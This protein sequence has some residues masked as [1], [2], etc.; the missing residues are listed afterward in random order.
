M[1]KSK[2]VYK[3][4]NALLYGIVRLLSKLAC[5]LLFH[6]K[7]ERNELVGTSGRRILICNHEAA[8]DFLPVYA[9]VKER[10]HMVA[11]NSIV[12]SIPVV[13]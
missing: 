3:R 7:V 5:K 11:S 13:A 2:T 8:I 6:L 10:C 9:A 1:K 12:M 4:P